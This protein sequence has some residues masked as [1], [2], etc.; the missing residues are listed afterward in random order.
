MNDVQFDKEKVADEAAEWL[1]RLEEQDSVQMQEAF[2][3]WYQASPAHQQA[4]DKMQSLWQLADQLPSV[5]LQAQ[6]QTSVV[7]LNTKAAR[8]PRNWQLGFGLAAGLALVIGFTLFSTQQ[9][10]QSVPL[11]ANSQPQTLRFS[12]DVGQLDKVQLSDGSWL[13]LGAHS[14]LLVNISAQ[15]RHIELLSGEARFE[16]AKDTSRPFIVSH[17]GHQAIALG[18]I[19]DVKAARM[20]THV[21]VLEGKVSVEG[22]IKQAPVTLLTAGQQVSIEQDGRLSEVIKN[23]QSSDWVVGRLRYTNAPLADVLFDVQRYSHLSLHINSAKVAAYS[24]TGSIKS[25]GI[26]SWLQSLPRLYELSLQQSA[27][28]VVLTDRIP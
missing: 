19:F 7:P 16:V 22:G 17:Q 15:Q 26:E 11:V 1:L 9:P 2:E 21:S 6:Q 14:E 28:T 18:T 20:A 12:T 3:K 25:D 5:E 23:S 10:I 13:Q 27:D 8:K 4:F 24:Y